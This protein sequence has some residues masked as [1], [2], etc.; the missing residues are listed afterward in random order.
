MYTYLARADARAHARTHARVH[1][2][3]QTQNTATH[4]VTDLAQDRILHIQMRQFRV[5]NEKLPRFR[6][7]ALGLTSYSNAAISFINPLQGHL[8]AIGAGSLVRHAH[9]ATR[10][11]LEFLA[12]FLK[13]QRPGLIDTR[14]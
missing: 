8:G 7:S 9:N 2:N 5:G 10:C 12:K 3:A 14:I 4:R 1:T 6:G 11:E 13:I